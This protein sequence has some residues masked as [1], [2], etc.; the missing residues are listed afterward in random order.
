MLFGGVL[1]ETTALGSAIASQSRAKPDAISQFARLSVSALK[2]LVYMTFFCV[3]VFLLLLP[4][5]A[6]IR[7]LGQCLL[8]R[9]PS[10]ELADAEPIRFDSAPPND[11]Q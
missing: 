6:L 1:S 4:A 10:D 9:S 3:P 11:E 7:K 5:C 8:G 2:I